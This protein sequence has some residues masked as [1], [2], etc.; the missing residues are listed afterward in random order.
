MEADKGISIGED[1]WIT[2]IDFDEKDNVNLLDVDAFPVF[3]FDFWDKLEIHCLAEC[4]G[5]HAYSFWEEDIKI[6][7]GKTDKAELVKCLILAKEE[8]A[9]RG[10]TIIISGK[11]NNLMH[12]QVFIQLLEH[13]IVTIQ[14]AEE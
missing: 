4:C 10:E 13:I 9:R 12:K 14:S 5:I 6:A 3:T 8:V 7:L 1:K 11:L 2:W